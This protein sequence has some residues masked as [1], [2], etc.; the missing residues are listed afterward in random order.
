MPLASVVSPKMLLGVGTALHFL[1]DALCACCLYELAV[2]GGV[3]GVAVVIVLYNVLAFLTQPLTGMLA[4]RL[5]E[6]R[7][8]LALS[9]VLLS[10]GVAVASVVASGF[11][12][13][14]QRVGLLVVAVLLGLGNSLF[15]VWGG[16]RVAV[17]TGNDMRALGV[18][19]STGA[20]GLAVGLL[21]HSWLLL[22]GLLLLTGLLAGLVMIGQ[23]GAYRQRAT[24]PHRCWGLLLLVLM[25]VVLLRSLVGQTFTVSLSHVGIGALA[26]G[27]VSMLG[28][29]WG[30]WLAR[31]LG[32][33]WSMVLVVAGV[34]ACLLA[35]HAGAVVLLAGLLLV[36]MTMAVTL[37]LA[38]VVLPG[39]EGLAFGLL[40]AALM[41]GYLL[42]QFA[43]EGFSVLPSLLLTLV[44]TIVI[45]LCVLWALRERRPDVLWSSVVVNVLTNVPLNL[46]ITYV[47]GSIAA[48]VAGEVLV[49]V[50]EAL[51]YAYF[52]RR[53]QQAFVY[54]FLCNGIS[55]VAGVLVM[56]LLTLFR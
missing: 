49:L 2:G 17:I 24:A 55:C 3:A 47:D 19:V 7:L 50:V 4:D 40:A 20:L 8:L 41:P 1:V 34:V 25:A 12:A 35:V 45:E 51:W 5:R 28:K 16:K 42:A 48:M 31:W 44:P 29:M 13:S 26:V 32:V 33:V 11:M 22:F 46:Y 18:F 43:G 15:H 23:C 10:L 39:R 14:L 54:S 37:W 21:F 27:L 36:N 30:G 53:W 52:V 9:V 38:N 56:L 6:P